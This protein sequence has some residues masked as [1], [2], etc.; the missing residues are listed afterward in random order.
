MGWRDRAE[1]GGAQGSADDLSWL[2]GTYWYV[3]TEYLPAMQQVNVTEPKITQ[4][5]DQTLWYFTEYSNGY[6]V[7]Q[8]SASVDGGDFT[9]QSIVGSVTPEG[10]VCLSFTPVGGISLHPV[11]GSISIASIIVGQ[12]KLVKHQGEWAFL[13][14]MT[15]GNGVYNLTHWAYM[16]QTRP[17]DK[18]WTNLPGTDGSQSVDEIFADWG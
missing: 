12:G 15:G 13:M 14:Q 7:G 2:V 6:L 10:S 18:S 4:V 11:R 1:E 5:N 16:M 17:G 3:P 9:Y 8:C